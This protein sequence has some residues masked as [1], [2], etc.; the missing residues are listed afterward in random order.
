MTSL[1]CSWLKTL[2][3]MIW[4]ALVMWSPKSH[5]GELYY[6]IL[7]Y[8]C[9]RVQI[10]MGRGRLGP[11]WSC[12]N[13]AHRSG[14]VETPRSLSSLSHQDQDVELD[15]ALWPKKSGTLIK[16]WQRW[17]VWNQRFNEQKHSLPKRFRTPSISLHFLRKTSMLNHQRNTDRKSFT[18]LFV[19]QLCIYLLMRSG[20]L[21]DGKQIKS[22]A[23][24][25]FC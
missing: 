21:R 8:E 19:T 18:F 13:V 17:R 2:K 24:F 7:R 5:N 15:S 16:L 25:D 3:N 6:F 10:Q 1:S 23:K 11:T 9:R 22:Y 4:N 14:K 20:G 12:I